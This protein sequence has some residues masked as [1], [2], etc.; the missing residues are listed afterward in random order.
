MNI[1]IIAGPN[2]ASTTSNYFKKLL[3]GDSELPEPR[4][5]DSAYKQVHNIIKII[6][7]VIANIIIERLLQYY[8]TDQINSFI[9]LINSR[10]IVYVPTTDTRNLYILQILNGKVI[11]A[12]GAINNNGE[13]KYQLIIENCPVVEF[14]SL[15][16]VLDI[17]PHLLYKIDFNIYLLDK[18]IK[19]MGKHFMLFIYN[20]CFQQHE[21]ISQNFEKKNQVCFKEN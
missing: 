1:A 5:I 13:I 6:R 16:D 21:M 9:S 2:S 20:I 4:S 19:I 14:T 3:G 7:T 11:G 12:L 18:K 8:S 10:L 17:L 15:N